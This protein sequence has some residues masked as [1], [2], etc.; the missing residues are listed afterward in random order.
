MVLLLGKLKQKQVFI[1]GICQP[2][3]FPGGYQNVFQVYEVVSAPAFR[4]ADPEFD[5]EPSN[6]GNLFAD[7]QL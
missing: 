4:K 6:S 7:H 5:S 1:F 3:S 2:D